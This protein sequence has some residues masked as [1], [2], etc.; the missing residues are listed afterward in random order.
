[1]T[2]EERQ[3][4]AKLREEQAEGLADYVRDTF[5]EDP[6]ASLAALTCILAE[7]IK[8]SHNPQGAWE[9]AKKAVDTWM[10]LPNMYLQTERKKQ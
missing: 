2:E 5:R 3:A 1:M 9:A 8:T 6:A 7:V 4:R 10:A